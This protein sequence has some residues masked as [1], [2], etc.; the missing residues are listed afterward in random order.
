MKTFAL[1]ASAFGLVAGLLVAAPEAQA[2]TAALTPIHK[3]AV[4]NAKRLRKR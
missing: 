3:T 1:A 2:Q 4:A